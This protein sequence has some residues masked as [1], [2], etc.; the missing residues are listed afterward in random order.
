MREEGTLPGSPEEV[1]EIEM[2]TGVMIRNQSVHLR[3]EEETCL[4]GLIHSPCC[5]CPP[6]FIGCSCV[7]ALTLVTE[8]LPCAGTILRGAVGTKEV[9]IPA[10]KGCVS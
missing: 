6:L 10:L 2:E 8:P 1:P 4:P 5:N 3:N 7:C 9:S